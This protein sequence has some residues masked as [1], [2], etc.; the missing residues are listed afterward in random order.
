MGTPGKVAIAPFISALHRRM[1]HGD[2]QLT[3]YGHEYEI[4]G[5]CS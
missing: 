1:L 4:L 5:V 3:L 2:G